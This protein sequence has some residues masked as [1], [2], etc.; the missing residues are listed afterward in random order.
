MHNIDGLI[1][2]CDGTL[3]HS[4]PLHYEAW[5]LT[6]AR[7]GLTF[8]EERFYALAGVPSQHIITLLAN[9]QGKPVADA[10]GMAKEKEQAFYE[11]LHRLES[12]PPVLQIAET[13]RGKKKMA[14]ASGGW[15]A[16]VR[17]QLTMIG[18]LDWFD[19]I[20]TAEDT[21]KHKPEPDV[22]L[23]AARRLNV[24]AARCIV[25]EDSELGFEAAR[26]A[27]M[28]WVDVRPMHKAFLAENAK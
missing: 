26:K 3:T 9:E 4:M 6:A 2:D 15:N 10:M 20:V 22:F 28:Q 24:P 18:C 21:E 11:L 5:S 1:F 12:I 25:Y 19:A 8:T 16:V 23:E 13:Y 17:R 7:Y 14:V 27:G